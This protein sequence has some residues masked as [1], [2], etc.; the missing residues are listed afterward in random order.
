[1]K[2]TMN[3]TYI[4]HYLKPLRGWHSFRKFFSKKGG[5]MHDYYLRREQEAP[6]NAAVIFICILLG[7]VLIIISALTG[8]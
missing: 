5:D 8:K 3:D 2:E 4:R 6:F 1:M 7:A